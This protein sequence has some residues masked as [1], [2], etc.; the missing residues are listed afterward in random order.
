MNIDQENFALFVNKAMTVE[1]VSQYAFSYR[2]KEALTLTIFYLRLEKGGF[3]DKLTCRSGTSYDFFMEAIV[4]SE[5]TSGLLLAGR[6]SA[7][8]ML[9][10]MKHLY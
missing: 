10:D 6:I 8:P 7:Q 4:F 2:V 5:T 1:N 3:L 9:A